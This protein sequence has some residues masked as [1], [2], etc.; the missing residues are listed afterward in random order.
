MEPAPPG[1]YEK[2]CDVAVY[3]DDGTAE[4]CENWIPPGCG[5]PR[6]RDT[7]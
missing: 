4:F 7:L 1:Y 6:C 5:M 3:P 2:I